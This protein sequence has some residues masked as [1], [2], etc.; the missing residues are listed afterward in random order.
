MSWWEWIIS[1]LLF[2]VALS[3]LI[4]IHELGHLSTAKLF[5]VYCHEYSIGFGPTLLKKK[6]KNGETYF[7]LRAIPLGGYVSMYGE[8]MELEPGV[9]IPNERS[10][11][12]IKKWKKL[13]ILSSGVIFN[14]ITAFVLIFVSNVAFPVVRT[15]SITKVTPESTAFVAGVR[16]DDKLQ[17]YYPKS[18]EID[19]NGVK[20]ISPFVTN[21]GQ[22]FFVV[23]T[24]VIHNDH[25]YVLGYYPV[26]TKHDNI[27]SECLTLY[28]GVSKEEAL[29]DPDYNATY[30][31]WINEEGSPA[32]YP[33]YKDNAFKF[34]NEEI[35]VKIRFKST[36][37]EI[38]EVTLPLKA[39][40]GNMVNF[41]V[42]LKLEN[43]WL[44]FG[45]RLTNTFA[46]FGEA[47]V[48]VFKGIGMI[49]TG[50]LKNMSGIV[51]IANYSAQLYGNYAFATYLYFWGLISINLAIFNLLPFPGLDG[52]QIL[53]TVI[54]GVSKKKVPDKVKSI[55]SFIGLA[56]L[57]ALMIAVLVMD[58]LRITGVM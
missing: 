20:K 19:D 26:T 17:I 18:H 13:I 28:V 45:K 1:I 29:A 42:S 7:T 37:D 22:A 44:P 36:L 5:N 23:D 38:K 34:I 2:I 32:Y 3:V 24:D 12:G 15:T 10:I 8:G 55:V 16:D 47:S 30:S 35:P 6:R 43:E 56:L 41:G 51:G 39:N 53:V 46:D 21:D 57:F 33:R 25:H 49:F 52:W 54:E 31:S 14:A 9:E 4:A 58:V 48:A 40:D 27:L 50:G 11:E